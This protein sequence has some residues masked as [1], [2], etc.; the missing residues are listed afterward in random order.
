[1]ALLI[2]F[3]SE[4]MRAMNGLDAARMFALVNMVGHDALWTSF[5]AKFVYG[6]WRPVTAIRTASIAAAKQRLTDDRTK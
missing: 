5:S 2:P 1:M 6:F 4:Q 3:L